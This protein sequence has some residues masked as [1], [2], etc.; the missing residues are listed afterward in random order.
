MAELRPYQEQAFQDIREAIRA[1]LHYDPAT[2]AWTWKKRMCGYPPW[3]GRHAGKSAGHRSAR[4]YVLI[5][6]EGK[7]YYAHRLAWLYVHGRWPQPEADHINGIRSDN[8]LC[9]LRE[10]T[11][12]QNVAHEKARQKLGVKGVRLRSS[13]KWGAHIEIDGRQRYL[14]TFDTMEAAHAAYSA[15]A[16]AQ[17]GPFAKPK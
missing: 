16:V 14:G 12:S 1:A 10:A 2:G 17:Y 4:G 8:R 15:A 3:N 7:A 5:R 6:F 13:G 11:R 9:N